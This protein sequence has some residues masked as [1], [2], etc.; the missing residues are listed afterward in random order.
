[1]FVSL[2]WTLR[3]LWRKQAWFSEK[4]GSVEEVVGSSDDKGSMI[5]SNL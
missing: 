5:R 4:D 2:G 3:S 1:M